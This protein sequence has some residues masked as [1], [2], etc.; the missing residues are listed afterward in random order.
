MEKNECVSEVAD[1][2]AQHVTLPPLGGQAGGPGMF[3]LKDPHE[4]VAVP[5]EAGFT[6]VECQPLTPT[7]LIGGDGPFDEPVEF[8]L[9]LG[10][11]RGLLSQAGPDARATTV[12]E[13][14]GSLAPRYEPDLRILVDGRWRQAP[15]TW[16]DVVVR[17][18]LT[19]NVVE[20]K[21]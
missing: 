10:I 7:V 18:T 5:G 16:A 15:S 19:A 12:E 4:I 9:G 21:V 11:V 6:G 13:I 17:Q 14:R 8:L 2:G 3:P 1:A 20:V